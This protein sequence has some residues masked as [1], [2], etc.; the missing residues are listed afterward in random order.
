MNPQKEP[1]LV[2]KI[3]VHDTE[4]ATQGVPLTKDKSAIMS[5]S[6]RIAGPCNTLKTIPP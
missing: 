2:T 3:D 6:S 4:A 1:R 5:L